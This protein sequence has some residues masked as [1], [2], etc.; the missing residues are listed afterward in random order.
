MRSILGYAGPVV[1]NVY[2]GLL[3]VCFL[4]IGWFSCYAIYRLWSGQR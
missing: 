4:A 1:E 3:I 2:L